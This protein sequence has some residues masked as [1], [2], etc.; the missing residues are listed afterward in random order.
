MNF[1]LIGKT[2]YSF[3]EIV[4]R[5]TYVIVFD[6]LISLMFFFYLSFSIAT[7]LFLFSKS[8]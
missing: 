1:Y 4:R 6:V 7:N 8:T 3:L 5:F 2:N